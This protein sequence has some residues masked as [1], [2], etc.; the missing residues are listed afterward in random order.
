MNGFAQTRFDTEAK[1]N[2]EVAYWSDC[3]IT[4]SPKLANGVKGLKEKIECIN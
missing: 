2:S 3:D 4:G 1:G